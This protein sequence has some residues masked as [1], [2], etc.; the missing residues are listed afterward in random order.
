DVFGE[1]FFQPCPVSIPPYTGPDLNSSIGNTPAIWAAGTRAELY[2][3]FVPKYQSQARREPNS[4]SG[5]HQEELMRGDGSDAGQGG[6]SSK[7]A[8]AESAMVAKTTGAAGRSSGTQEVQ[9]S[10]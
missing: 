10:V 3:L 5:G 4:T 2:G 6:H 8:T 7:D 1:P 9:S